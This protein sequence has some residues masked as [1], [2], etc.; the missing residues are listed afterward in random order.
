[1]SLL[2]HMSYPSFNLIFTLFQVRKKSAKVLEMEEFEKFEKVKEVK[3]VKKPAKVPKMPPGATLLSPE[4]PVTTLLKSGGSA[5]KVKHPKAVSGSALTIDDA[6]PPP[7]KI[8]KSKLMFKIGS[9][10]KMKMGDL[11]AAASPGVPQSTTPLKTETHASVP[12]SKS[13]GNM[14]NSH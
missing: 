12:V 4:K 11:G 3:P 10:L 1:M 14:V 7:P 13:R 6:I 5:K 2:A 8:S 9:D